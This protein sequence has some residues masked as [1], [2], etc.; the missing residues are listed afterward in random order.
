M[1]RVQGLYAVTDSVLVGKVSI[2]KK[3]VLKSIMSL[4]VIANVDAKVATSPEKAGGFGWFGI[5]EK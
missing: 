5:G 2:V 1:A 4:K 3:Q